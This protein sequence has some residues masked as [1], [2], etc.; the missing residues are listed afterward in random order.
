MTYCFRSPAKINLFLRILHKRNDGYHELASLFQ[1][2]NFFDHL[3]FSFS[4]EDKLTC[5]DPKLSCGIDNTI[6]RAIQLFRKKTGITHH[7]NVQLEKNIPQESGLGG[8]SSNCATTLFALNQICAT[9]ISQELLINWASEISADAPFFFSTG[10]AFCQGIGEK[11]QSLSPLP[12]LAQQKIFI[13]KPAEG[14]ST[15]TIFTH[16][17]L[18]E[19]SLENPHHLLEN[20]L[21][22]QPV[23]HNDLEG[24][25]H[26]LCPALPSFKQELLKIGFDW[27]FMTGS[28]T[29]HIGLGENINIVPH[30]QKYFLSMEENI[31]FSTVN[32]NIEK[33]Y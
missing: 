33:W 3:A 11:V 1:A 22:N 23:F 27:L 28:G 8:G 18:E 6:I 15:K 31:S 29:A 25:A 17:D 2:V 26:K 19:C 16:L 21:R 30:L 32:R 24:I 14:L 7:F 13:V 12:W 10:T 20:F 5:N 9:K 4:S